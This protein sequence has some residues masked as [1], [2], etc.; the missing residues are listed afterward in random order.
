MSFKIASKFREA[1][2]VINTIPVEKFPLML[3]RVIQKL[4]IRNSK[5]F[6]TEEENQLM[7]IFELSNEKLKLVLDGCCYIFEQAAYSST[8]PEPLYQILL[9]AGF[10]EPHGKVIGR[11]WATE[12]SGFVSKLKGRTLGNVTLQSVDYHLNLHMSSN[13][14]AKT[15]DPTAILEFCL[16][17][18]DEFS[19]GSSKETDLLTVE[20]GHQEL[21]EFFNNIDRIQKQLDSLSPS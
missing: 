1:A 4:H 14:A 18:P 9:E 19:T 21:F 10:D 12:A 13:T 2:A 15:Q 7:S 20:F 6:N 11:T 17:R 8:G 16:G 3:N 5:L